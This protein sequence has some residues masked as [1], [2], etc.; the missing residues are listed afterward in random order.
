M[1][2]EQTKRTHSNLSSSSESESPL[3]KKYCVSQVSPN[4]MADKDSS[5]EASKEANIFGEA[6]E[7]AKALNMMMS[8]T[9]DKVNQ[10]ESKIM[11]LDLL[12]SQ[13]SETAAVSEK[14]AKES[15]EMAGKTNEN[16]RQMEEK[17]A[18]LEKRCR[19]TEKRLQYQEDYSR[20]QNLIVEGIDE[21]KD[22]NNDTV[23]QHI[24]TMF[25]NQFNVS[26]PNDI[27]L[28]RCHRIGKKYPHQRKP[29]PI[30]LRFNWFG[31]RERIWS[32]RSKLQGSNIYLKEDYSATT[33][34]DRQLLYPYVKAAR[35]AGV[36]CSLI[37][38]RLLIGGRSYTS[39]DTQSIPLNLSK[40]SMKE[41]EPDK[42]L[43]HGKDTFLSNFFPCAFTVDEVR[44]NCSEQFYQCEKAKLF[45]DPETVDKI[46]N[47]DLAV[48]QMSLGKNIKGF[49]KEK[50]QD[51]AV[52]SMSKG[53][54]AKFC[55]N[56]ELAAKLNAT[57]E[58]TIAESSKFDLYWGTGKSLLDKSAFSNWEGKNQMGQVIME[59]RSKLRKE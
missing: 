27:K 56:P 25:H 55:Q 51:N 41:N 15:I 4:K 49:E 11:S 33:N 38:D 3:D 57:G 30:I 16:V 32:Y 14:I 18:H 35:V 48:E 7:W 13:A 58:K 45:K 31:D 36:K 20:R 29:R 34:A 43:F 2:K 19:D 12:A 54:M 1:D 17:I 52:E 26:N 9:Y 22:E 39:D 46:M 44:Y 5:K 6:P 40:G 37:A 50:W 28:E 42:I 10:M 47:S 21:I 8:K 53:V 59:V 24:Y 23:R